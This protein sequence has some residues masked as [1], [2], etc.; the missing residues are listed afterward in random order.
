M[1]NIKLC[2]CGCGQTVIGH[3][4]KL[5]I[6]GHKDIFWN[7][8]RVKNGY[9]KRKGRKNRHN[10][11]INGKDV[12]IAGRKIWFDTTEKLFEFNGEFF[13][14]KAEVER[15]ITHEEAEME[16][17]MDYLSGCGDK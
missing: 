1:N 15:A 11:I 6:E 5:F 2:K 14:T 16:C 7:K 12:I 4:N 13:T 9:F 8:T 17:G 3:K 10:Y